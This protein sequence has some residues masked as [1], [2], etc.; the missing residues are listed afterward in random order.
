MS[1]NK[2][3][4]AAGEANLSGSE[5]RAAPRYMILQRCLVW[6]GV[7]G[8]NSRGPDGW[9]CIAYDISAVGI[10]LTLPLPVQAGTLLEIVGWG[11]TTSRP[12][13]ARVVHTTPVEFLWFSGCEFVDRLSESEL[14]TWLVKPYNAQVEE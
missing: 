11:L 8:S 10:G 9:H 14:S 5:R 6:S 1:S 3:E 2:G 7:Q 4:L 12:L 13:R